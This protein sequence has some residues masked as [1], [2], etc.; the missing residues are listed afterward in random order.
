MSC[1]VSKWWHLELFDSASDSKI[2]RNVGA[3]DRKS[4]L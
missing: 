2:N 1:E 3:D 4:V